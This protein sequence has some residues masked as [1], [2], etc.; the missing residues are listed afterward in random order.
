MTKQAL[1]AE[2]VTI[3]ARRAVCMHGPPQVRIAISIHLEERRRWG[4]NVHASADRGCV[5]DSNNLSEDFT[6]LKPSKM[7]H[8]RLDCKKS[9]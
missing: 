3:H 4:D 7:D 6:K 2:N 8:A 9:I 5:H 1:R